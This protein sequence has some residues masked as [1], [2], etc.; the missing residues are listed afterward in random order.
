MPGS[1]Y[2]FD[3]TAA[4]VVRVMFRGRKPLV[5]D[6]GAGAGKGA[7][8]FGPPLSREVHG[9]EIFRKYID[10]FDL[11]TKYAEVFCGNIMDWS[12]CQLSKYD[13]LVAGDVL[14]HLT[15]D[16][17]RKLIRNCQLSGCSMIVQVPFLYEQG[18][19]NGNEYERHIQPDLTR[20]LMAVRYPMLFEVLADPRL[21]LYIL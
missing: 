16:D 2:R 5:L 11:R 19:E 18:P 9:L 7:T 8:V 3:A 20:D 1:D 14:E 17:A 21:G 4:A 15:I 10:E 6:V 13:L 12:P